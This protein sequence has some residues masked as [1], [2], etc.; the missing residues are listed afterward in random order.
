MRPKSSSDERLAE[1]NT[2]TLQSS[3]CID[4]SANRLRRVSKSLKLGSYRARIRPR[5]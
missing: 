4:D 2:R 1:V 3:N 5:H